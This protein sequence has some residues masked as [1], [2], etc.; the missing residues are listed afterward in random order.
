MKYSNTTG[1]FKEGEPVFANANP[2]QKLLVRRYLDR[3]YYCHSETPPQKDAV[4][5]ERELSPWKP[6]N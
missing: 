1:K 3:I 6:Q 4:F 5:F 2:S